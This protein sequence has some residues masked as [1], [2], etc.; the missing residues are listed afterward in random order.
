MMGGHVTVIQ[1]MGVVVIIHVIPMRVVAM[2]TVPVISIMDV[3]GVIQIFA[4]VMVI[5]GV[6][7][8]ANVTKILDVVIATVI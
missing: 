7:Q 5:M 4:L 6:E 2:A 1:I 3:G 8:T